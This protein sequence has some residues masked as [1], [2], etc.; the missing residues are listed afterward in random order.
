MKNNPSVTRR[1][2]L[3]TAATAAGATVIPPFILPSSILGAGGQVA[4]SNRITLGFIG[5]GD[6]GINRNLKGFLAYAEAHVIAVCDVDAKRREQAKNL[7]EEQY[8]GALKQGT[9]KVALPATISRTACPKGRRR[10]DDFPP[11]HW[12]VIPA[13]LATQAGK[14]V[15]CESR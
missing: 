4:P 9:S 2:F 15:M 3:A 13:I 10:R 1:R 14:D 12:H 6:H 11:D 7:V 5:T 8:A